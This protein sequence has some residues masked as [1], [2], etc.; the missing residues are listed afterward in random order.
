M[1]IDA[2]PGDGVEAGE[3]GLIN[4]RLR[5]GALHRRG[6]RHWY[7]HAVSILHP[8]ARG[9]LAILVFL[10]DD[11]AHVANRLLAVFLLLD[12]L[13]VEASTRTVVPLRAAA[14]AGAGVDASEAR[15]RNERQAAVR[16]LGE[17]GQ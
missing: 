3:E 11:L 9:D 8:H 12:A 1:D 13:G 6:I 15:M 7:E 14:N 10:E 5:C 4:R 2:L 17:A 16:H